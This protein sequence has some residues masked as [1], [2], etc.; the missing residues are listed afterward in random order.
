MMDY[1]NTYNACEESIVTTMT[2]ENNDG[3]SGEVILNY[4]CLNQVETKLFLT[5]N[6]GHDWPTDLNSYDIIAS[7]EIWQFLRQFDMNGRIIQ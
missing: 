1:W 6:M 7:D 2:D 5:K 3:E 4:L